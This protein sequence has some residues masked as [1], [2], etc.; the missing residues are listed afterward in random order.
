[1]EPKQLAQFCHTLRLRIRLGIAYAC[2]V[3]ALLVLGAFTAPHGWYR[4]FLAGLLSGIDIVVMIYRGDDMR[5]ALAG[6]A[7]RHTGRTAQAGR[8]MPPRIR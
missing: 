5:G 1:M 3:L 2:L 7:A 6:H 4:G 8:S